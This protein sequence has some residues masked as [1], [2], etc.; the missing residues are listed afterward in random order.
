MTAAEFREARKALR[1]SVD[2][3]AGLLGIEAR[4]VR[5]YEDG[6]R[7]VSGPVSKLVRLA[8]IAKVRR[9]IEML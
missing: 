6:T 9:A 1:L 4:S 8:K 3:M 7:G 5:R 2:D